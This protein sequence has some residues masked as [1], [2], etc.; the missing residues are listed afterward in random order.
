MSK[1]PPPTDIV[2]R[3]ATVSSQ[4]PYAV[5]WAEAGG[6]PRRVSAR[7]QAGP[8]HLAERFA[9]SAASESA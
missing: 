4:M 6:R 3:A 9:S 7:S 5:G 8:G 2:A 1:L